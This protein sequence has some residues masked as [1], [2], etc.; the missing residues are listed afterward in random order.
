[1]ILPSTARKNDGLCMPCK[2]GDLPGADADDPN[3]DAPLV[4]AV[5]A[6]VIIP[7]LIGAT[8]LFDGFNWLLLPGRL[9]ERGV[10]TV[11][12]SE[13]KVEE[14][15]RTKKAG[16]KVHSYITSHHAVF[17]AEDG[18]RYRVDIPG[19]LES[20]VQLFPTGQAMQLR[21]LPDD[22]W[23]CDFRLEGHRERMSEFQDQLDSYQLANEARIKMSPLVLEEP[24]D[25]RGFVSLNVSHLMLTHPWLKHERLQSD[26]RLQGATLSSA[27]DAFAG[28]DSSNGLGNM[29]SKP[30]RYPPDASRYDAVA[31]LNRVAATERVEIKL[32]CDLHGAKCRQLLV[33][34][35][36]KVSTDPVAL[37]PADARTVECK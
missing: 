31:I 21:Y 13:V 26:A 23:S 17:K 22:P 10:T 36:S 16:G 2:R 15:S 29:T 3:M 7:V 28:A 11:G 19:G 25:E 6:V 37:S 5:I 32:Q 18:D 27:C 14:H 20:L 9:D 35:G 34:F 24:E 8:I 4:I 12:H 33:S 30:H 1:M